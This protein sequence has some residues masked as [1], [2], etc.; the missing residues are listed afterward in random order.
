MFI[1]FDFRAFGEFF[2]DA[3]IQYDREKERNEQILREE[4]RIK[5]EQKERKKAEESR[6]EFDLYGFNLK[7]KDPEEDKILPYGWSPFGF[8]L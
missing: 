3:A 8:Y 1:P 4:K 2:A 5:K 6:F 7:E